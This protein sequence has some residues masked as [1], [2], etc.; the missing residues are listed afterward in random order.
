MEFKDY[1][2]DVLTIL[3][4]YLDELRVQKENAIEVEQLKLA[5]PKLKIPVP[6]FCT[7]TW[8]ELKS[9]GLLPKFREQVPYSPRLDGVGR[10]VPNTTLK[11]PTGGGK[12]LLAA[13]SVSKIFGRYLSSNTGIVLWIVPNE[14]IYSQTKKQLTNREHPFRQILDRAAAGRVKILEKDDPLNK[15][16][17][18]T[19]MCVMLLMLQS[20]NRETKETLRLFRDRGNVHGFF[21]LEDDFQAHH[22][23]LQAIPNLSCY[24]Q[25]DSKQLGSIVH[26]S[27]GNVLR[28][29]RPVVVI[30][31]G[32]K[33]F[34]QKALDTVYGFNPIFVLELSATPK[35]K[36]SDKPPTYSNWLVDV[37]GSDLA[38]EEMIKL[39][40]NVKVKAGDDWRDCLRESLEHLNKLHG[41][42]E[43]LLSNTATYIRPILL[44][45]VERTGKDQRETGFIHAED[46]KEFL[47][48]AGLTEREI[49]IKTSEVNDLKSPENQNLLSQTNTI[50]V[51]ITKQAL[52]EGWDCSFAYV[53][54]SLA[55]SNNL[56][57]MTQ[58]VGRILRQPYAIKTKVDNLDQCFVFCH[59]ANTKE[60]VAG[61]KDS[62]EK[63][64]MA[65]LVQEIRDSDGFGSS[66]TAK[67]KVPRRK[68]FERLKIYLPVVNYVAN[69][70]MRHLDYEQD[71]LMDVEWNCIDVA[72]LIASIPENV[73]LIKSQMTQITVT[74]GENGEFFQTAPS[75]AVDEISLFDP[76][77]ATRIVSDIVPNP[78]V[79]R[80]IIS[81]IIAGLEA[82]GFDSDKIGML[83]TF[84]LEE[85]RKFL[86]TKRDDLA[87][88]I[89]FHK[90]ERKNIQFRLRTDAHNWEMPDY[91]WTELAE[92]AA[93]LIRKSGDVVEKSLFAPAYKQD[94]NGDEDDFACYL[95]EHQAL[96]WWHRNVAKSGQ[97]YVQGWRKN[98][99]YPDFI[100]AVKGKKIVVIET[101]GDQLEGNLDTKYKQKLLTAI[102]KNFSV[103]KTQKAGE[104]ELVFDDQTTISCDMLLMSEWQTKIHQH[105]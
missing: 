4:S 68:G 32:H 62:L 75:K 83:S 58:L 29:L 13:A 85:L 44:V 80:E 105:I 79:A 78:W 87:E 16:D 49:A 86:I 15:L 77:Y 56:N 57:A 82:R 67:R 24:N 42:A 53:L 48:T 91:I 72:P 18:D 101:K 71:I 69:G 30:D 47:L 5:N 31:E 97:Y 12:T 74:D 54:C 11:I 66:K 45:Q 9:K 34:S 64:G 23:L 81:K 17:L 7:D 59:H 39:P 25:Q 40:I 2:E 43:K 21:P 61:I 60:V 8:N 36:L 38:K 33:A 94:F 3:D 52:Q 99:V 50:R 96:V 10:H 92:N 65:D 1:Q 20:A 27:L 51:I 73:T 26:D 103:D 93:K 41:D 55:A 70:Q 22:S 104:L 76:V 46:A 95:D 89:F 19:H 6:D 90:V 84:I 98:K 14:A 37:R 88:Q 100:F 102:N 63:E 35:D 28:V